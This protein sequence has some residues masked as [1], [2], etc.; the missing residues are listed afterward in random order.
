MAITSGFFNSS[1]SDRKYTAENFNDYFEGLVS[2]GVFE[3][4]GDGLRVTAGTGMQVQIGTGKLVDSKGRWM[5][6]DAVMNLTISAADVT[7]NRYDA[8]VVKIDSTQSVRGASIYVKKGTAASNPVEPTMTRNA[9]IEEYC[10]AYIYV[11]KGASSITQSVI[12]D[13]RTNTRVCGFVMGLIEKVD[14][15]DL[16]KQYDTA[17]NEWFDKVKANLDSVDVADLWTTLN[18]TKIVNTNGTPQI[19]V[20]RSSSIL[21]EFVNEGVGFHTIWAA[22]GANDYPESNAHAH[23]GWGHLLDSE[24]GIIFMTDL[25]NQMMYCNVINNGTWRGWCLIGGGDSGWVN[26]S[27]KSGITAYS[28]DWTPK[29]RRHGNLVFLKGTV[30]GIVTNNTT[31]AQLPMSGFRPGSVHT[32]AQVIKTVGG[33]TY[34]A[35]WQIGTNGEISLKGTGDYS[36]ASTDLFAI[37]T[38]FIVD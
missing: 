1:N 25:V 15:T 7:L 8:I 9:T 18:T 30:K 26:L 34:F 13:T 11:A 19:K 36:P 35:Y 27:L 23:Y 32:F 33:N 14:T 22:V 37:D 2:G 10:L 38:S 24:N 6:N 21:T 16:F 12:T 17:F 4:V 5:K 3:G 28:S 31:I 20:A 29:Y